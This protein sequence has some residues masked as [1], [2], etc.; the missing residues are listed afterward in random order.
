[1]KEILKQEHF[2]RRIGEIMEYYL[3][4]RTIATEVRC[5]A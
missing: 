3:N 4:Y 5:A 1:M 2:D